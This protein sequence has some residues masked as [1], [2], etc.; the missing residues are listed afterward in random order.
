MTS[1]YTNIGALAAQNN[2]EKSMNSMNQ[3]MERLSSGLRI[4]S[5]SDDAA[6]ASISSRMEAQVRG[7][8]QAVR[9]SQDAQNL[10][11]TIEGASIEVVTS[12][13]RLRELAVQSS[14]D[15]LSSLDRTFLKDE[16]T[17]LI[18][19]I[20]RI[21]DTT[22]YNG[23]NVLDGTYLSKYFQVGHMKDEEI[24]V[25]VNSVKTNAIGS[26]QLSGA[27][28][29]YV[30]TDG[31]SDTNTT[32]LTV[33]GYL[34][35][36]T[37]AVSAGDSAKD[38]AA[39]I[40]ADTSSTGVTATAVTYAKISAIS[41]AEGLTFGMTSDNSTS[42]T[43]AVT[44]T[45][46]DDLTILRDA[47]NSASGVT[48]VTASFFE[49]DQ[50]ALLLTHATGEDIAFTNVTFDTNTTT[51]TLQALEADASTAADTTGATAGDGA[52]DFMVTG[53]V[54]ASSIAAFTVAGDGTDDAGFFDTDATDSD[55]TET[56]GTATLT[57]LS[58]ID[59]GTQTGSGTA[60]EII[61][62]AIDMVNDIRSDLGAVS[63]RL[64]KTINNLTNVMENTTASKS[65][66]TDA[67]FAA[68]TSN[69]TKAQILSQA[70][71]SMLA[72]ANASKQNLLALLQ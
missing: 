24:E 27:G 9:N 58:S 11:D 42:Q 14:S 46:V 17:A 68:E 39:A 36:A 7:L 5:A 18:A 3:A 70:A 6:G 54:T 8:S 16:A 28:K 64:D 71:T 57:A 40:N 56:G 30:V 52:N 35:A 65:Q 53:T 62:G 44:I 72:Q 43:I 13:Q 26:F 31:A 12:L 2:M 50:S 45:D 25:S 33:D 4:N 21:G 55:T 61:D 51:M 1:I 41:V 66:I 49:G 15:T 60:I 22:A 10:I 38:Q 20:D 19:E 63:N 29:A 67:D 48:G 34:G 23:S 59:I 37:A 47:F 32:A 69:L